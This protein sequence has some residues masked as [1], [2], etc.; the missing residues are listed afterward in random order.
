MT[1][2]GTSAILTV[3]QH[4]GQGWV[5]GGV[6][7]VVMSG[8][9]SIENT[10]LL[11]CSKKGPINVFFSAATNCSG[12][13]SVHRGEVMIHFPEFK[14]KALILLPINSNFSLSAAP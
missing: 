5:R 12:M 10:K 7:R 11:H 8:E 4:D 13:K 14:P 6:G 2:A 3:M 1:E 9:G